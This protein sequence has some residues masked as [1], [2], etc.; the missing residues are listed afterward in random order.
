MEARVSKACAYTPAPSRLLLVFLATAVVFCAEPAKAQPLYQAESTNFVVRAPDARLAQTIARMAEDYRRELSIEWLGYEIPQWQERCPIRVEIGMHAGGET[1]FAFVGGGENS[2]GT[3]ISWQM[4]IFGPPDRLLDAVLPHEVTHTIF[5]THFGRPLPRWADEGACTTVEHASEREKNHRML[6]EFLT[7]TPSR[8]I[9]FN[10]M[11]VM[12]EYPSDI[13]PLYAQGYSLAKFLIKQKGKR[14]FVDY[15][16][17]GLRAESRSNPL[18]AWDRVT[19]EVYGYKNLSELQVGWLAWVK[20]GSKDIDL[21]ATYAVAQN[22]PPASA[23]T[24]KAASESWYIQQSQLSQPQRIAANRRSIMTA[25][26]D[27]KQ[28]NPKS[29]T[30]PG[31]R[32]DTIW[33]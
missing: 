1:S 30:K 12:R 18:T 3:P 22:A 23:P 31:V 9:P 27:L 10:R 21:P 5:A 26:T 20:K 15:V 25:Q 11:F 28:V 19:N 13:L 7:S 32:S 16:S 24:N 8:G 29:Q 2:K 33:R 6:M 17:S 4:R 14:Q